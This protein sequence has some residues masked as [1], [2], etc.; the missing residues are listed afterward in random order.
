MSRSDK[1][2]QRNAPGE[3][4]WQLLRKHNPIIKH[5]GHSPTSKKA[6]VT[7]TAQT[8]EKRDKIKLPPDA[9][10]E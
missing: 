3:A 5:D 4:V 7:L 1:L 10:D 6:F 2:P 8:Y 9:R